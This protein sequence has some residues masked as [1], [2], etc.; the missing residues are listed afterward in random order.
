[1]KK[2]R[3]NKK[4]RL[5]CEYDDEDEEEERPVKKLKRSKK[6]EKQEI[7]P[8]DE[9]QITINFNENKKGLKKYDHS[10]DDIDIPL[11]YEEKNN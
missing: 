7:L 9:E 10:K 8:I 1:M 3:E 6:E 11:A 5:E 2:I 4:Q